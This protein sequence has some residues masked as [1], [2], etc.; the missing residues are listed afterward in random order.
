MEY[1]LEQGTGDSVDIFCKVGSFFK[2]FK[3]RE[4]NSIWRFLA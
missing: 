2:K 3:T 4:F 1:Q